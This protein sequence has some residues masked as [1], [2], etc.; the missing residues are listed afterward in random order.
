MVEGEALY[1]YSGANL[2]GTE[3]NY[4][5]TWTW[6]G[7][8][9][10][11]QNGYTYTWTLPIGTSTVDSNYFIVQAEGYGP[12]TNVFHPCPSTWDSNNSSSG[13]FCTG[14]APYDCKDDILCSTTNVKFC[15]EAVNNMQRGS[16][17]YTANGDSLAISGN[18][19]ANWEQ[20]GCSVKI[21][22]TDEDGNN[23]QITSDEMW[24]AYQDIRNIGGCHV[25]GSKHFGNGC[26]VNVD[27]YY[28]CD[29]RDPG[30]NR[31]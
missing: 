11:E 6:L 5:W 8:T 31:M 18:C 14:K 20:F 27:Y 9:P 29:N 12:L 15:D 21:R 17:I 4:P 16:T 28:G 13:A 19:W 10:V 3:T 24:D 30:P 7:Y 26:L 23:C 22:G 1:Q 2:T 25:C